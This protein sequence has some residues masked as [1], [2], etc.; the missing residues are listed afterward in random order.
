MTELEM[1]TTMELKAEIASRHGE[2]II[3]TD[4]R[5][6][7]DIVTVYVKTPRGSKARPDKNYDL[8]VATEMMNDAQRELTMNYLDD[9]P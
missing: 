5:K 7:P 4:D 3:I 8:I 1:A 6:N 2:C 9:A